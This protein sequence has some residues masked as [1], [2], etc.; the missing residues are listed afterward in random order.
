MVLVPVGTPEGTPLH[1]EINC[2]WA[3]VKTPRGTNTKVTSANGHFCAY[4]NHAPQAAHVLQSARPRA[5]QPQAGERAPAAPPL[6][7]PTACSPPACDRGAR[8]R[9]GG[10][11]TWRL[12]P[13][14]VQLQLPLDALACCPG[15]WPI[16][17]LSFLLHAGPRRLL[18]AD[19]ALLSSVVGLG[20]DAELG[21]S[22]SAPVEVGADPGPSS[23]S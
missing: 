16:H 23:S 19:V 12:G 4:P 18:T 2:S 9:R 20:A 22:S 7:L 14:A 11:G 6:A 15:G 3:P 10:Q 1:L 21:P 5:R 13:R 17:R 8:R